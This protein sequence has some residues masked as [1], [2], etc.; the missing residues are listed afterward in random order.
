MAPVVIRTLIGDDEPIARQV[1][2]EGLEAMPGVTVVGEAA[3]GREALLQIGEVRPDLV[4]LDLQ[5][6]VM[7]GF[8][9]VRELGGGH[10]PVVVIVTAFD[11]HAIEAFEAGGIDYLLETG[12]ENKVRR[13]GERTRRLVGRAMGNT[14]APAGL[15]SAGR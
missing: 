13:G 14:K 4:F 15:V 5:M 6:P 7:G 2:R 12:G 10:L 3:N 1:V 9:V 11:E 8:E